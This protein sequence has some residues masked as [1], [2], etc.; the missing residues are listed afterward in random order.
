[1]EEEQTFEKMFSQQDGVEDLPVP[2]EGIS[3]ES[4]AY[5]HQEN[6]FGNEDPGQRHSSANWRCQMV[7]TNV[8]SHLR[9]D[10]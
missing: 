5:D 1:M 8:E 4:D 3:V 7:F 6:S 10:T 9:Q 2:T